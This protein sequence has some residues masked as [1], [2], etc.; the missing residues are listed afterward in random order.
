MTEQQGSQL[1][2]GLLQALKEERHLSVL[3]IGP[4]QPETVAFFSAF[5]CRLYFNDLFAELPL[6][7]SDDEDNSLQQR[8]RELLWYADDVRFDICLFWD[9]F[10]Y[11]DEAAVTAVVDVLRS[12]MVPGGR[13]HC[14]SVHNTRSEQ[15]DRKYAIVAEDELKLRPRE[16]RL[17]GYRPHP[18]GR[19]K[20]LLQGL[21]VER[22]VLLADSRLELLLRAPGGPRPGGPRKGDPR[23]GDPREGG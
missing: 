16:R 15:R 1:L 13:A 20:Q 14:F 23:K 17:E 19:L 4:V 22:S 3:H 8:V 18:Q 21:E 11:L 7:R 5:P 10:N 12:R 9:I 2:S 6:S